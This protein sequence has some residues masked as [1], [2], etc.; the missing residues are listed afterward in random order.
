MLPPLYEIALCCISR[1]WEGVEGRVG[2]GG[3]SEGVPEAETLMGVGL[4]GWM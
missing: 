1:I 3:G 4:V 2:G